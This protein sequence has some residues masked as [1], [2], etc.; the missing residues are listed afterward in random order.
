LT[1]RAEPG[2]PAL[3]GTHTFHHPA[4]GTLDLFIAPVGGRVAGQATYEAC[5]SRHVSAQ[6]AACQ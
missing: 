5:F 6:D 4:L 3:D 1:F 2:A